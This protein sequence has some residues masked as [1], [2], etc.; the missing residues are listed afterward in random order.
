LYP[1]AAG[2]RRRPRELVAMA[3]DERLRVKLDGLVREHEELESRMQDPEVIANTSE[4]QNLLRRA[5]RTGKVV[6]VYRDYLVAERQHG[7]TRA[8]LETEKD[9]EMVQLAKEE[10]ATLDS[11][12][13]RLTG[14][15]LD[16]LLTRDDQSDKNAIVE[17]RAG[18]GGEE[19]ALFAG[20]LF[21]M[22]ARHAEKRGWKIEVMDE[23]PSGMGGYKEIIF[24]LSG[25]EVFRFMRYESGG[26]RVQRVPKTESQGRIHTSAVTVA[27]L[28]EAEDVDIDIQTNELRIDTFRS[29][30]PGGQ[31]VNKTSSA[32]RITHVPTGTVV[33]CQDEKSQHKNKAKAMRILRARLY[34]QIA[35][36]KE[37]ERARERKT[38]IGSGDRS[39]RI[40]TYNFPQNRVTDHRI[41]LTLYNLEQVML[42]DLDE[43]FQHLIA[44]EREEKLK[45]L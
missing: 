42:G 2:P 9:P 27:V 12:R 40:R 15:V 31:S 7:E 29:S 16:L 10:L 8:L 45:S 37:A 44:Y 14:E 3:I 18:T 17:I 19:A 5:G 33:S 35:G 32:V 13:A 39:Q 30:G 22:Y 20:D 28:P 38:Q 24:G 43:L 6:D 4:Y 34:D 26:H 1:A 23:S 36:Q 11:E 21:R 41:N 25:R